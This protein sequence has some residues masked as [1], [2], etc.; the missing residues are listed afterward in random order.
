MDFKKPYLDENSLLEISTLEALGEG[1]LLVE[2][3]NTFEATTPEILSR[4]LKAFESSDVAALQKQAH[5]LKSSSAS[6]GLLRLYEMTSYIE[7]N[8]GLVIEEKQ[9]EL[10]R[11]LKSAYFETLSALENFIDTHQIRRVA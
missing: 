5:S 2:L 4:I 10:I 8:A 1:S 11:D 7:T 6:L 3:I 9:E